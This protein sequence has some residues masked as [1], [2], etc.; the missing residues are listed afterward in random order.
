LKVSGPRS[1]H[2]YLADDSRPEIGWSDAQRRLADGRTYW[3]ATVRDD[4][5][6]HAMPLLAVWVDESLHFCAGA[7]TRKAKNLARQPACVISTSVSDMDLVLDGKAVR[8][9]DAARVRRVADEYQRK[10]GW[11]AEP[12]GSA[13]HAEGAPTAGPP[14]LDVYA[15]VPRVAF[16][17][18]TDKSFNAMRWSFEDGDGN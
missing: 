12:R 15:I 9:T 5:R 8:V 10:Y 1:S 11:N 4:G 13:L 16:G 6:P 18:G 2:R 3:L 7:G 17:F 14:P